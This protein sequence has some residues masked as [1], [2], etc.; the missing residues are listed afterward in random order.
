KTAL[1]SAL[2]DGASQTV[3]VDCAALEDTENDRTYVRAL[4]QQMRFAGGVN[5][6][7]G[8]GA[9]C[10]FDN[11][12]EMPP[13]V[14]KALRNV[15]ESFETQDDPSRARTSVI[16]T[17]RTSLKH[18]VEHGSFRDDLYY[19]LAGAPVVLPPLR[20]RERPENLADVLAHNIAGHHVE[21]SKEAR[22]A[23]ASADWPGNVRELRNTL[24]QALVNGDGERI[25]ALDLFMTATSIASPP[26]SPTKF[27]KLTE[28]DLILDALQSARWNVSKAARNLGIGR[29]TIH[30]KMKT[31]E[32]SRPA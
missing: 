18:S 19:M 1:V 13:F 14:Q 10:V 26:R 27:P 3:I 4:I 8:H 17:C 20:E 24:E 32:I 21:I 28:K 2:T 16:G 9:V 6:D 30:R 23:I 15:L 31:L 25:T 7:A 11:L 22:D 5:Q 29:A 12:N